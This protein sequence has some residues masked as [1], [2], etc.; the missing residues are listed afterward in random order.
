MRKS[1]LAADELGYTSE[2]TTQNMLNYGMKTRINIVHST[3]W[4]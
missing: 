3:H 1:G 4:S 2:N